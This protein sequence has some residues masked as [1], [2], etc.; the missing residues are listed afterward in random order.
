MIGEIGGICSPI[1]L[2]GFK[3]RR[4]WR[5]MDA[6]VSGNVAQGQSGRFIS[7]RSVVRTHPLPPTPHSIGGNVRRYAYHANSAYSP[8]NSQPKS[9]RGIRQQLGRDVIARVET[10]H[11]GI[12]P[13]KSAVSLDAIFFQRHN[14]YFRDA[15]CAHRAACRP[16]MPIS[17]QVMTL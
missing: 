2:N 12:P 1:P 14:L 6:L 17:R 10:T 9:N 7:A 4:I 13:F 11:R 15:N 16:H 5:I 3:S 8:L